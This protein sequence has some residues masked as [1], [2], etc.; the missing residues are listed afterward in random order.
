V[1]AGIASGASLSLLV[2]EALCPALGLSAPNHCYPASSHVRGFVTHL[3]YGLA[4]AASAEAMHRIADR[5]TR[6]ASPRH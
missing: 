5:R 6:R 2:D 1:A 3:V 4:L